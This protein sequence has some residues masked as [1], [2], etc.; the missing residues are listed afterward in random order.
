VYGCVDTLDSLI[1]VL[2]MS[3]SIAS[4]PLCVK[5]ALASTWNQ[6]LRVTIK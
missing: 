4:I 5:I 3:G 2:T 1:L 6:R